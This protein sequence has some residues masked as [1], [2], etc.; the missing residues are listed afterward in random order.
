MLIWRHEIPQRGYDDEPVEQGA[1]W[2]PE[3]DIY[4]DR[5]G[6]VLVVA[7]PGVREDEIEITGAGTTLTVAG[8]RSLP[9]PP[10]ATTHRIELL[11]GRFER[12]VRLPAGVDLGKARSQLREGLLVI[13]VPKTERAVRVRIDVKT[14]S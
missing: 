10:N 7:L 8:T 13:Q 6:F 9:V 11:R 14:R 4:E 12:R 1:N 2:R 5:E 3:V